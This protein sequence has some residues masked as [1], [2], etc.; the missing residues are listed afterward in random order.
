MTQWFAFIQTHT[1][2]FNHFHSLIHFLHHFCRHCFANSSGLCEL[3]LWAD[4]GTNRGRWDGPKIELW[5]WGRTHQGSP[6]PSWDFEISQQRAMLVLNYVLDPLHICFMRWNLKMS[7]E[8]TLPH[9]S[10]FSRSSGLLTRRGIYG[11]SSAQLRNVNL[12]PMKV[13]KCCVLDYSSPFQRQ[14]G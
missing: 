12:S 4:T 11:N 2:I 6:D 7:C 1:Y 13:F 3:S 9:W 5:A 14:K 8:R 10:S